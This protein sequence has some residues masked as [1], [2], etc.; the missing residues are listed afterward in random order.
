VITA[1]GG[2]R[3]NLSEKLTPRDI[4]PGIIGLL[5]RRNP[6]VVHGG[7]RAIPATAH[8]A[9]AA[10]LSEKHTRESAKPA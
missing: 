2:D 1:T 4:P 3:T 5:T 8:F 7:S 9:A 10:S 6:A